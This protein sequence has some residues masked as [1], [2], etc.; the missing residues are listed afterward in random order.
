MPAARPPRL[1]AAARAV[2]SSPV[3][4]VLGWLALL[5]LAYWS[6]VDERG[7]WLFKLDSFV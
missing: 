1:V 7:Q 2:A 4:A 3:V 6:L 5:V